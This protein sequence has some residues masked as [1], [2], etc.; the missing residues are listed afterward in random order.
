MQEEAIESALAGLAPAAAAAAAAW[1]RSEDVTAGQLRA[2]TVT[3]ADLEEAGLDAGA[4]AAIAAW[5]NAQG[6]VT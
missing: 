4:R 6:M 5:R 3:D 1:L 2:G